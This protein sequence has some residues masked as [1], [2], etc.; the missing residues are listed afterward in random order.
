[1]IGD[2][3]FGLRNSCLS[4]LCGKNLD[5]TFFYSFVTLQRISSK[6]SFLSKYESKKWEAP[7]S[8]WENDLTNWIL[9]ENSVWDLLDWKLTL[10]FKLILLS[11]SFN[12]SSLSELPNQIWIAQEV[13]AGAWRWWIGSI[14]MQIKIGSA[15]M[16]IKRQPSRII[17]KLLLL[18]ISFNC[19]FE[20]Q[21]LIWIAGGLKMV[22]RFNKD[23]D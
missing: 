12:C 18:N 15:K 17:S 10:D 9:K 23:A 5:L 11:W 21:N 14:K 20:L 13:S 16:Q 6:F 3:K 19:L 2:G 8:A 4:D 22:N 1:M 7:D